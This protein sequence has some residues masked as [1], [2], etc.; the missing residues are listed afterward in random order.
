ML[1]IQ[2][3]QKERAE[4]KESFIGAGVCHKPCQYYSLSSWAQVTLMTRKHLDDWRFGA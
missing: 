1:P 4:P 3:A 2:T